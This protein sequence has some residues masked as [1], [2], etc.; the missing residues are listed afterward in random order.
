M[1]YLIGGDLVFMLARLFG[2]WLMLICVIAGQSDVR[3]EEAGCL[4]VLQL[5]PEIDST[6]GAEKCA[7][8]QCVS[9]YS[10]LEHQENWDVDDEPDETNAQVVVLCSDWK[11]VFKEYV[12]L[13]AA[14][15]VKCQKFPCREPAIPPPKRQ[16]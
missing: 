12:S 13:V 15:S 5:S 14:P 11:N 2:I 3:G 4:R 16:V 9:E 8:C 1:Q 7:S 10:V 6:V